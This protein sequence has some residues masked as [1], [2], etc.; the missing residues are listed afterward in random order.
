[1]RWAQAPGVIYSDDPRVTGNIEAGDYIQVLT[2]RP[3]SEGLI[4][5]KVYPHDFREVGK[6]DGQVW[7]DWGGLEMFRFDLTAFTCEG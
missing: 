1:M 3:T 5:V 4:R 2:P 6:T 7:I